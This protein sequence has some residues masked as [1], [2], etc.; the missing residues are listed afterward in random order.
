MKRTATIAIVSFLAGSLWA[1][2]PWKEKPYQNWTE[3]DVRQILNESPWAK[4]VELE[5]NEPRLTAGRGSEEASVG[6]ETGG[7]G[8]DGEGS[9]GEEGRDE[10]RG[11]VTFVV[12]WVSSRTMREAWVRGEVLQKRISATDTAKFLPPPSDDS[13]LVIVGRDM[14]L[15]EK[16]DD[17]TLREKSFL[18]RTR[19]KLKISPTVVQIVHLPV[20]KKIKA[21]VFHFPKSRLLN[22]S[23]PLDT[24]DNYVKFV[25]H[26]GAAEIKTSFDLQRMIDN[27]GGD[28]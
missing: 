12:R 20:G 13:Q 11:S 8:G 28:L 4:R 6:S 24:D 25:S 18:L 1:G 15:F 26:S 10:K 23:T 17:S 7:A 5:I 14:R 9:D 16:E 21:I 22:Q 19:S 3:K 2:N 27:E